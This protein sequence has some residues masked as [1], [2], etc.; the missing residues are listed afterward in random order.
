MPQVLCNAPATFQYAIDII[1]ND[2]KSLYVLIYLDKIYV[3]L[4]TFS[5]YLKHLEEVFIRLANTSLKL[6]SKK[7][8]FF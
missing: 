3:F 8:H 6:K 5:E 1:F 7:C 2:L 4:Y